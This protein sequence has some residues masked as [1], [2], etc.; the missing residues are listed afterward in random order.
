MMLVI[1]EEPDGTTWNTCSMDSYHII[2]VYVRLLEQ[3]VFY[4]IL[5]ISRTRNN[6]FFTLGETSSASDDR[7]PLT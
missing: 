6:G 2:A 1:L 5:L 3:K 7:S 4:M